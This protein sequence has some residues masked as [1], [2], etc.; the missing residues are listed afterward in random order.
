MTIIEAMYEDGVLKPLQPIPL[1]EKTK[2]KIK[3]LTPIDPKKIFQNMVI[4]K[5]PNID[6]KK[7]KDAYYE[8]L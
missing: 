4:R 6:Y 1:K 8:T 3:I 2:V 7:L 5:V